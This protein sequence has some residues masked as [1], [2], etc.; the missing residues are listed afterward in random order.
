VRA[1]RERD[2][3]INERNTLKLGPAL[4]AYLDCYQAAICELALGHELVGN[5]TD[6]DLVG[7]SVQ[8]AAWLMT[9]MGSLSP[10]RPSIS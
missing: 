9:G 10:V 8:S 6:F 7:E 3:A 5:Q 2:I 1:A 4:A